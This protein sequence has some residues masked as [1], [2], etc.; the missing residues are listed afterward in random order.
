MDQFDRFLA[1]TR[2]VI[3]NQ[4]YVVAASDSQMTLL[5]DRCPYCKGVKLNDQDFCFKCAEHGNNWPVLA[6]RRV[7][8]MPSAGF[9]AYG[10]AKGNDTF[11][12]GMYR[13]KT[14]QD[15]TAVSMLWN[16]LVDTLMTHQACLESE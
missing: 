11:G 16:L 15:P 2:S 7:V 1:Q 6:N 12:Q 9:I 13:Y 4:T 10:D 14:R 5:H 8:K 3:D